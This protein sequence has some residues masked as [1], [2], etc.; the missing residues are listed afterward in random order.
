M[1]FVSNSSL[2]VGTVFRPDLDSI[3]LLFL[4]KPDSEEIGFRFYVAMAV[5]FLLFVVWVG[6]WMGRGGRGRGRGRGRGGDGTK[7]AK[8][9]KKKVSINLG[10]LSKLA[11]C[12]ENH[13]L[14]RF[15]HFR[16]PSYVCSSLGNL[17]TLH[18]L[19]TFAHHSKAL[20][21]F[22]ATLAHYVCL[23]RGNPDTY[24]EKQIPRTHKTEM[25][26]RDTHAS[27]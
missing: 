6:V 23:R 1:S 21:R 27:C 19:A 16:K 18:L 12:F 2:W 7:A 24:L 9:E 4:F 8:K 25:R 3:W 20:L 22:L 5:C 13:I 14:L 17:A 26:Q 10:S 11:S 15:L